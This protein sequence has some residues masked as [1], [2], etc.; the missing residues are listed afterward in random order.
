LL[1]AGPAILL[2]A[3]WVPDTRPVAA[4]ALVAGW[5]VL[6]A[7][8]REAAVAWAAV[9][10]V[11]VALTWPWILGA[12]V[13]LGVS[14]CVDPLSAIAI[15]R[16][17]AAVAVLAIVA[18]LA[19]SHR[20]GADELGFRRPGRTEVVLGGGG[21]LVLAVGGL[22]L[23]PAIARP[24]FGPLEF[25]VPPGAIVPAIVFGV[26]N[27]VLEEVSYRGAMQAWLGRVAPAW[28]AIVYQGVVFGI[29]HA[30]P[31]VVALVA[32]HASL[33]AVVG[34]A[35]GIV[36]RSTG[37]LAIPIGIHVGADIALYVGLACRAAS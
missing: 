28:A 19:V 10:P 22:L 4:V 3:A 13:P 21:L 6:R 27:G 31:D 14:G 7:R 32:V 24:F 5:L 34:I 8:G 11:G 16:L 18:L 30:G 33:L 36:R 37:S 12:D 2:V 35:G 20:S 26:A 29:V 25:P 17:V 23:G 1:S 9:L 15:R